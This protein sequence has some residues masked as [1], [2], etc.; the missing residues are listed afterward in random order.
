MPALQDDQNDDRAGEDDQ[1]GDVV[2]SP[3]SHVMGRID[4]QPLH[5]ETTKGVDHD[6]KGEQTAM[7]ELPATIRPDQERRPCQAPHQLVQEGGMKGCVLQIPRRSMGE[8]DLKSPWQGRRA[9]AFP[10]VEAVVPGT[11]GTEVELMV[12]DDVVQAPTDDASDD[13]EGT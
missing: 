1:G 8:V 2:E 6:I 4:A 12:C 13:R 7:V 11:A 10:D 3:L 5:P 9:P